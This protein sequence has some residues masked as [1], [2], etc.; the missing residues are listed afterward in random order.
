ML[1]FLKIFIKKII[2]I[3][4]KDMGFCFW[5]GL[6]IEFS[7]L[8]YVF[9]YFQRVFLSERSSLFFGW[10]QIAKKLY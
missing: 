2:L 8:F 9:I 1:Q 6:E 5:F 4:A 3:W 7:S 10:L